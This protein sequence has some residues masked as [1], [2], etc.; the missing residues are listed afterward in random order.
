MWNGELK[1]GQL[2][3]STAGRDRDKLFLVYDIL[4]AA[5]VRVVDGDGRKVQNPK[6]KNMRHLQA[7]SAVAGEIA[8]RLVRG[9]R[10]TDEEVARAI[11]ELGSA[12]ISEDGRT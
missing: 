8:A 3:K 5:F 2:V 1:V 6:K 12:G 10:V 9:D 11:G 7:I 4:N